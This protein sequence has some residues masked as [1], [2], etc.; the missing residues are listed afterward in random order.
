[1]APDKR[2]HS[3]KCIHI[4][5]LTMKYR[6]KKNYVIF[7]IEC[8]LE[9]RDFLKDKSEHR[10]DYTDDA[11]IQ[12]NLVELERMYHCYLLILNRQYKRDSIIDSLID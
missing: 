9:G 2:L 5:E 4:R 11:E 12:S 1:M 10:I 3:N 7:Y 6:I 8:D